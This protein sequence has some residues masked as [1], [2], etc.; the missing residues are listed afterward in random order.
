MLVV[1]DDYN[2]QKLYDLVDTLQKFIHG[3]DVNKNTANTSAE[4][5]EERALFTHNRLYY[6]DNHL[7]DVSF[8]Y[9]ILPCPKYNDEQDGYLTVV[10]NPVTLWGIMSDPTAEEQ[11]KYS[12]VM[13]VLAYHGYSQTTPA[14]FEVN[15]KAKHSESDEASMMFDYIR[16]GVRHDLARIFPTDLLSANMIELVTAVI[17]NN[18]SWASMYGTY[19]RGIKKKLGKVVEA[20]EALQDS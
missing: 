13:E 17:W 12:A 10:G 4:F 20:Y 15:Y 14:I 6:A 9:T 3:T 19:A 5:K 1:S 2:C 8:I 7:K 11:T 16:N 18:E